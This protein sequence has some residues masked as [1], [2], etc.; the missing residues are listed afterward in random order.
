MRFFGN[1]ISKDVEENIVLSNNTHK[2]DIKSCNMDQLEHILLGMNEP[3][4]RAKQIFGWLHV[5]KVRTF[6][7][8]TNLSK[9]LISHLNEKYYIPSI[10]IKK[11]LVS[12]QD[13][14]IKYLYE[15][16]D[17]ATIEAV[18]MQYHHGNSLCIS[19]QVGCKMG[20]KFCA[21]TIGGL[22][23]NLSP[24]E[25]LLE[26]ETAQ[27]D[28]GTKISNVVLMGIGEPFD[29]FQNVVR[30]LQL[31]SHPDGHALSLRGVTV[32]T[33]GLVNKIDE[34]AKYNFSLTLAVSLHAANDE[35]R[36]KTMPISKKYS[37]AE[38]LDAC[39][40]YSTKTGRRITY[41]YALI[42]N[43]NDSL[44]SAH[45]LGKLLKGSLCHVN[46]IQVN[47]ITG[48]Q[49]TKSSTKIA[50]SFVKIL[51]HYGVAA[52]IRRTLGNDISAACGQLRRE[53]TNI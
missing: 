19:T 32:S 22:V 33:C 9:K 53:T 6:G 14:T 2:M 10:N 37:I 41:E 8:M 34:L 1:A 16:E 13:N 29:N 5:K 23:R 3:K 4:Y 48:G 43:Q 45:E 24:S 35:I 46:L 7:E 47:P 40:K 15:L 25:M 28:T 30:F 17:G 31:L 51:A 36:G 44:N 12:A 11:K 20:C 18:Y 52:T 50:E 42:K 49:Y 27:Q 39:H 21:S 38:I 26:I